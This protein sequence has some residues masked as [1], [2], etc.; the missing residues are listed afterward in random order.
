MWQIHR[1]HQWALLENLI[2]DFKHGHR[3]EWFCRTIPEAT[4]I[5][6]NINSSSTPNDKNRWMWQWHEKKEDE[7][8]QFDKKKICQFLFFKFYNFCPISDTDKFRLDEAN[9]RGG[10]IL[11]AFQTIAHF[12]SEQAEPVIKYFV[13]RSVVC[14]C[15]SGEKKE[16]ERQVRFFLF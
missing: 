7:H 1:Q 11:F 14:V 3:V 4:N 13:N 12:R 9:A 2:S 5:N 16:R 8:Y 15:W 6:I 10:F